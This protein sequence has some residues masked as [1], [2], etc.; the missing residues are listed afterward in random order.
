MKRT[1]KEF[2]VENRSSAPRPSF[3]STKPD[4]LVPIHGGGPCSFTSGADLF[5][6]DPRRV[7][8]NE[9]APDPVWGHGTLVEQPSP[10]VCSTP[11]YDGIRPLGMALMGYGWLWLPDSCCAHKTSG[12]TFNSCF[13]YVALLLG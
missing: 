12:R 9:N 3:N 8:K 4:S 11:P 2:A 6:S 10:E 1:K 7:D 5:L 13:D